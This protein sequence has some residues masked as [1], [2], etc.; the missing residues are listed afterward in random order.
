MLGDATAADAA[1]AHAK[2]LADSYSDPFERGT[3]GISELQARA[4]MGRVGGTAELAAGLHAALTTAKLD[5]MAA[6]A[7]VIECWALALGPEATD[8][9]DEM[10]AALAVH[11][12]DGTRIYLPLYY[13]L[14]ADVEWVR[15]RVDAAREALRLAESTAGA[16]GE[17]VWDRQL[18]DRLSVMRSASARLTS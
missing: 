4:I 18:A 8:T 3:V 1:L 6:S 2:V 11:T 5:Q 17:S 15:G 12:H 10:R 9:A 13:Q 16:T 14:L 7:K